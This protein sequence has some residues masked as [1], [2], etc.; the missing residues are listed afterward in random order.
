MEI[1]E[2]IHEISEIKLRDFPWSR[3]HEVS[4]L[5]DGQIG[6]RIWGASPSVSV[7]EAR[8]SSSFNKAFEGTLRGPWRSASLKHRRCNSVFMLCGGNLWWSFSLNIKTDRAGKPFSPHQH[9]NA[10]N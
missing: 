1:M 6:G 5:E 7:V 3:W 2:H 4:L 10:E 9:L 8:I